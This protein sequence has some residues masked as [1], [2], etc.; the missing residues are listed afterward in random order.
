MQIKSLHLES[1]LI[2]A[3]LA[4]YTDLAFRL[5][6]R[7]FGA[8]L[9][10]TE[11]ISCHGL[12]YQK[13]K[14]QL[15]TRTVPEER[16]VALQLFGADPIIMGEAA[17][18]VSD[19]PVDIID[20]NMGCPVRKVTKKGAGAALMKDAYLAATIISEVCNNTNLPVTVK[21][22]TGW[23]HDSI[24]APDFAK[25]AEDNGASAIA[26]HGRT[27]SQGFVGQVDWQTIARVKKNVAIPVIG[28]GDVNT[29]QEALQFMDNTGCDGIMIGR[30]A[31][32]NPWVF[33][34]EGIPTSLAKRM[35]GLK[36]HLELIQD[37]S[38]TDK[39]LPKIKTQA[40]QYFKG[41]AGGSAIRMQ[42]YQA[43]SFDEILKLT[44]SL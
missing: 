21:I 8:G 32:G 40:G 28:N 22:R 11:M 6:C 15:L 43:G 16:P 26:V 33:S 35:A 37:F 44:Q 24:V 41:I 36:R 4:G 18:L 23:N 9:C 30:A 2:L 1:P 38:N 14:T 34:P 3:P 31:L 20:I 12:V 25:M 7:Q 10:Y 39:I 27:W 29:Y 19:M 5:L 17:A 42:I 13:E